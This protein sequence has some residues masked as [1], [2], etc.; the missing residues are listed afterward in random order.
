MSI[1]INK[2][3]VEIDTL[4]KQ[5]ENDLVSIKE[6]YKKLKELEKKISQIK[7]IDINLADKLKKDYESLKRIIL[8]ENIQVK[9]TNDI[10]EINTQLDNMKNNFCISVKE[11]GAIGDGKNDDTN[12]IKMAINYAIQNKC[13][14]YFPNGNYKSKKIEIIG[15]PLTSGDDLDIAI[16]G[17]SSKTTTI[18]CIDDECLFSFKGQYTT[19]RCQLRNVVIKSLRIISKDKNNLAF[20]FDIC[21]HFTLEDLWIRGFKN[22][23]FYFRDSFDFQYNNIDIFQCARANSTD[24]Y[25]YAITFDSNYDNCNAHK[26]INSRLEYCELFINSNGNNRHNFFTNVK[27][28]KGTIDNNSGLSPFYFRDVRELSFNQC[29][30]TYANAT[31]TNPLDGGLPYITSLYESVSPSAQFIKFTNCNFACS[32]ESRCVWYKGN[33]VIFETCDF[34]GLICNDSNYIAFDFRRNNTLNNCFVRLDDN[35]RLLRINGLYNT[36]K[37][38]RIVLQATENTLA[39]FTFDSGSNNNIIEYKIANGEIPRDYINAPAFGINGNIFLKQNIVKD[40]QNT[41]RV[42]NSYVDRVNCDFIEHD[43]NKLTGM[44]YMYNGQIVT[45][46]FKQNCTLVNSETLL[47]LTGTDVTFKQGEICRL[48]L[49]DEK[50]I[51]V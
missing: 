13:G 37:N 24:D 42:S 48:L 9:L 32:G 49:L 47:T 41:I 4:F 35:S 3:E 31:N 51:Q 38:L 23:A 39:L 8:D 11:F 5:N 46:Y 40:I 20:K 30:F 45:V 12:S 36:I 33:G 16:I 10:N 21:Q 1:D 7:Y 25:A 17:E 27:F 6:L 28:E 29:F 26:F 50:L 2:H 19:R 14:I 15:Q 44:N 34:Y 22:G 18:E 43:S